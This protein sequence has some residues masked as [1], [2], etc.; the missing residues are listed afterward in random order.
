MLN[1]ASPAHQ[2]HCASFKHS[3]RWGV[4]CRDLRSHPHSA[5]YTHNALPACHNNPCIQKRDPVHRTQNSHRGLW[6]FM[7]PCKKGAGCPDQSDEHLDRYY[8]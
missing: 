7:L 5:E 1:P 2:N 4:R 3:C 6:D 8:H